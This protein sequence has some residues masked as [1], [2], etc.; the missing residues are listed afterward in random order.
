MGAMSGLAQRHGGEKL[1]IVT[2]GG[3][4]DILF[5]LASGHPLGGPRQCDIPN[6]GINRVRTDGRRVEIVSWAD[7]AHLAGMPPQPVY[8]QARLAAPPPAD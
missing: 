1:V 5:R 8:D 6:A 7:T 2:H 3:V 4:L